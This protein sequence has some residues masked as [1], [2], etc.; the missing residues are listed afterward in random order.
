M[1]RIARAG[2]RA[3]GRRTG[4][5]GHRLSLPRAVLPGTNCPFTW[6][7]KSAKAALGPCHD[8][9]VSALGNILI[10]T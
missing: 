5:G 10:N 4:R 8:L 7:F 6:L 9:Q 1:K 3:Q 2:A